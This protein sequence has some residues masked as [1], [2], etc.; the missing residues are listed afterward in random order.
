M[1]LA[2][3][4]SDCNIKAD[5][6]AALLLAKRWREEVVL[7]ITSGGDS[8]AL[9]T[10]VSGSNHDNWPEADRKFLDHVETYIKKALEAYITANNITVPEIIAGGDQNG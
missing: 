7:K 5:S 2:L 4:L 3:V 8:Q 1:A 6:P 10:P 9:S